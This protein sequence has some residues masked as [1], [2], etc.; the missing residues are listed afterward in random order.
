M[1]NKE[2]VTLGGYEVSK[3]LVDQYVA[4]FIENQ[5]ADPSFATIA[6]SAR[7]A[8]LHR[9]LRKSVGLKGYWS[10][11]RNDPFDKALFD[12]SMM[13]MKKDKRYIDYMRVKRAELNK[14]S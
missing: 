8:Y 6:L 12:L 14:E 10:S 5:A 9:D 4:W 3:A 11:D 2:T 7:L 1:V 13:E